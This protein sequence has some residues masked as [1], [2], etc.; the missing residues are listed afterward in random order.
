MGR[1][2][3]FALKLLLEEERARLQK[4]VV[5][6]KPYIVTSEEGKPVKIEVPAPEKTTKIIHHRNMAP[7]LTLV[8][9]TGSGRLVEAIIRFSE[10]EP[11][12][13]ILVDGAQHI[14][15]LREV[16]EI[17]SYS[18]DIIYVEEDEFKV[19][20]FKNI[21]F[22]R[23]LYIRVNSLTPTRIDEAYAK[24]ELSET[25]TPG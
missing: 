25:I 7:P 23:R 14:Y 6:E 17:S 3:D 13:A 19:V 1:L 18:S 11:I 24:V 4:P 5:V 9:I 21:A 2:L 12:I 10:G 15:T 22:N 8:D 20:A 16:M